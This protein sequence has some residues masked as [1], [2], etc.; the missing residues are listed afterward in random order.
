MRRLTRLAAAALPALC[1]WSCGPVVDDESLAPLSALVLSRPRADTQLLEGFHQLEAGAWRWTK[2]RFA[3]ALAPPAGASS[4]G[5]KLMLRFTLPD[6]VIS[7]KKAVTLSSA[8]AGTPLAPET[9]TKAGN[10]FYTRFVPASALANPP[11]KATFALDPYAKA[12]E[13]DERELGLVLHSVGLYEN[14]K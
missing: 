4:R 6:T 9:Y 12:G 13:I 11:L 8:I 7:R 5:A 14:G 10:Y 2:G 3:V 1:A